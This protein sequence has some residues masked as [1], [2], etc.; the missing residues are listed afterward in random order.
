M[1]E[2]VK[3]L[4]Q[5]L[6]A[7]QEDG[8]RYVRFELPDLHGTARAKIVPLAAARDYVRNGLNMYGGVVVLDTRSD[9]VGGT[10][11]NEE[12]QY[13]DQLIHPDPDTGAVL[14]WRTDMARWICRT[15]WEDGTPLGAAPRQV[16]ERVLDAAADMGY[17][18]LTG[19]EYEFYLLDREGQPLFG[20]Y[21]IFN[22]VRNQWHP[23]V[24]EII[25]MVQQVGVDLITANAE[26]GPSQFEFNY[27]PGLGLAGP[28]KSYTFKNAAK[29][30]AQRHDLN[31]T[32]MSKPF[33][34]FAGSGAHFHISLLDLKTKKN[35]MGDATKD[36]RISDVCRHFIGGNLRLATATYP[37]LVPTVNCYKR[38][39]PHTFSPTNVSWGHEDRSALIR[40]KGG[41]IESRHVEHR[42]PSSLSNPYLVAAAVLAAGLVGIREQIDPGPPS[43]GMPAEDNP[44]YEQ[45]PTAPRTA[46]A[47]LEQSAPLRELLGDE[48]ID[49]YLVMRRY[50]LQRFDDHVTDWERT[51]YQEIF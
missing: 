14:P 11:Y 18:I 26:Y 38:R 23:V 7:W 35:V 42:A 36:G 34:G 39:R 13:A 50:E 2:R 51:E 32:F 1:T 3:R 17:T 28:D 25:E 41:S 37:L 15:Q 5:Q 20:G 30:I 6:D 49:A 40:L 19:S 27:G 9:V 48:F 21:H 31:V 47:A 4:E 44:A 43:S 22:P 12:T 45:L 33:A 46:L 10:L 16:L 8:V 29:E 24:D